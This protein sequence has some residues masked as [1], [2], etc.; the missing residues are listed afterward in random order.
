[1]FEPNR[2]IH[3]SKFSLLCYDKLRP[4][5]SQVIEIPTMDDAVM[6]TTTDDRQINVT[7]KE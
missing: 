4:M 7:E 2:M 1:M 6:P 5:L 3:Q